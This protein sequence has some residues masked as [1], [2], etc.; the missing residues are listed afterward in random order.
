MSAYG[1]YSSTFSKIFAIWQ[2]LFL[3]LHRGFDAARSVMSAYDDVFYFQNLHSVLNHGE[4]IEGVAHGKGGKNT[5]GH[6]GSL[7]PTTLGFFGKAPQI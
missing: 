1:S 3:V 7:I 6:H 2:M 5:R 4:A